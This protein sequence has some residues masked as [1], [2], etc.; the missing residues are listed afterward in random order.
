MYVKR[1]QT[2]RDSAQVEL[3]GVIEVTT[4][5]RPSIKKGRYR[6]RLVV[7]VIASDQILPGE[8]SNETTE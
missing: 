1:E 5:G 6:S 2:A 4:Y 8:D 7:Q 3:I